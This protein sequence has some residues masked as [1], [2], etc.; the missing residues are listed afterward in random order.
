VL[1]DLRRT[2]ISRG[3]RLGFSYF[4][5]K[6]LANHGFVRDI[7][8]GYIVFDVEQLREPMQRITNEFLMLM[9]CNVNDWKFAANAIDS[10]A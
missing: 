3:E 9:G 7:T 10:K 8:A 6:R 4:M 5:L 1:H 2:F